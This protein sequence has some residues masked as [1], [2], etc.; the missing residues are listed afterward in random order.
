MDLSST[1]IGVVFIILCIMP[2]V[3]LSANRKRK[4]NQLLD[5]LKVL[6]TENNTEAG[7]FESSG[8]FILALDK[9]KSFFLFC[10]RDKDEFFSK[11]IALAGVTHC[12]VVETTKSVN[13]SEG[14]Y[15]MIDKLEMYFQFGNAGK[16]TE[17]VEIYK[18]ENDMQLGEEIKLIENWAQKIN[19]M[20]K[21]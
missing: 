12:K 10:K 5:A 1:I 3:F 4:L 13:T 14:Q 6:A 11:A 2:I 8:D 19:Q 20:I 21:K 17:I 7:D 15:Q 18:A 9:N 16:S